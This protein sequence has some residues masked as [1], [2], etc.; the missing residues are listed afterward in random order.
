MF[1]V[2]ALIEKAKSDLEISKEITQENK[3]FLKG[4]GVQ[5]TNLNKSTIE[6]QKEKEKTKQ[7]EMQI[8]N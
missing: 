8:G 4:V 7:S 2:K 6:V 3:I 5:K 1:D